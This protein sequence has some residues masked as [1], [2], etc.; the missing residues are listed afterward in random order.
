M[1]NRF[2][3]MVMNDPI[4][5]RITRFSSSKLRIQLL[6][7]LLFGLLWHPALK[8]EGTKQVMPSPTHGTAMLI[9]PSTRT[10]PLLNATPQNRL[11][12]NIKDNV[13]ED[14]YFGFNPMQRAPSK[15]VPT[16][17]YYKITDPS[18]AVV[19]PPAL[20]PLSGTGFIATYAQAIAGPNVNGLNP[21]GY[22]PLK[23][24]P[25]LSGDYYF[26][27]YRSNDAGVTMVTGNPSEAFLAYFDFTVSDAN[28]NVI[29]GR[30]H[31]QKWSFICYNP[32]DSTPGQQW[33]FLGSYFAYT[34]D[35]SVVSVNFQPGLMPLAYVL[36]MNYAGL[37]T[38]NNGNWL[39]NRAS[40]YSGAVT[41][42]FPGGYKIFLN[43]PDPTVF[44]RSAAAKQPILSNN[45]FGCP[46]NYFIPFYIDKP[47]DIALLIDL[48]GVPGY[49]AGTRDVTIELYGQTAGNHVLSWN[50]LDGLGV[51]VPTPV[52]PLAMSVILLRGRTS[53]PI[54][55]AEINQNGFSASGISPAPGPRKLYW[56]DASLMV[57]GPC[58]TGGAVQ[59][60]NNITGPGVSMTTALLGL[61]GPVHSWDG[62]GANFSVPA[63]ANGGGSSTTV[64]CDD[65]GNARIINTWFY[66][67]ETASIVE[68]LNV[69]GCDHDQDGIPDQVDIDDDN[70][71]VTDLNES[72]LVDPVA[73]ANGN[74][75]PNFIDPTYPGFI[76]LNF[77][78]VN[79]NF[80]T[81]MDGII[82]AW[83]VDSDNDGI[84][85]GVEA[86]GGTAPPGF[87]NGTGRFTGAVG[88]NGM[89]DVAET[90]PESGISILQNPDTDGDGFKDMYDLDSDNDG[91]VDIYEAQTGGAPYVPP[92]GIDADQ[93]GRDDAYDG[94]SA[95]LAADTDGDGQADYLDLDGDND[96][97]P[98]VTE[99]GNGSLDVNNDGRIDSTTDVDGDGLPDVADGTNTTNTP[100]F[101][102]GNTSDVF[103]TTNLNAP[104]N[105]V[106]ADNDGLPN[107]ADL[108]ADGD[109][110]PDITETGNGA[111]DVNNDGRIDSATD[112]D[113]DGLRDVVDGVNNN[114][115]GGFVAG[116]PSDV[117]DNDNMNN[118]S[119]DINAD[120][121]GIPNYLDLD[122]DND[123]MPDITET[124]NGILDVNND[125]QVDSSVDV[126]GDGLMDLTDG[127]NNSGAAGFTAG[128][129]GDVIDNDNMNNAS[130]DINA[131]ND[132]IPNYLDLDS[133][134]DGI[135]DLTETSNGNFDVNN[136]GMIDNATDLDLDGLMDV[137]DGMNNSAVVG[138]SS[139]AASNVIDNDN[140]NNLSNDINFDG[141]AIPNYLDLDSDNDGIADIAEALNGTLDINNDGM[142]DSATDVDMDGL[143]DAVDGVNNSGAGGFTA[144]SAGDV[145]DNDN[146]DNPAND[147]NFDLDGLPNYLDLDADNDGI[148][149]IDEAMNSPLDANNDG[150]ADNATD[151]DGDGLYDAVDGMNNTGVGGFTAGSPT[152]VVDN[153]NFNNPSND[154]NSDSD[155]QPNW[156][157]LDSDN[158]GLTDVVENANG[159]T[160]LDS[161]AGTAI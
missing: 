78:G 72:G 11:K 147:I 123:G 15:G 64:L 102:A 86:N 149:D 9:S 7:L 129:A 28:F 161:G 153:D 101:V 124:L 62:P 99:S 76:D 35:S 51:P 40:N 79:D 63:Q 91:I 52:S 104:G 6:S 8:A 48:N 138:F 159:N 67:N 127:V 94:S 100:G 131:D 68:T 49:Q 82:D 47:G 117:I 134:N 77:D 130:N 140:P 12:V 16:N 59:A 89:P 85:D 25:A 107:W 31:S 90:S 125:G 113:M 27:I 37:D 1:I 13:S 75:V 114:G 55:D 29:N 97:I 56:D 26:E 126:D 141:D 145:I 42:R 115:A 120:N 110:I 155:A 88:L 19:V 38:T 119:N 103:V 111:W 133:D 21:A 60:L 5:N 50:G 118:A 4:R 108:D 135:P 54:F 20:V 84:A 112:A 158:D 81:D 157:D 74:L 53:L 69:P 137:V 66:S 136:D 58:S 156:L 93:N 146:L 122:S 22:T 121:D 14:I 43:E 92:S 143:Q 17:L 73:D 41:P 80:D 45:V 23:L 142:I 95:L 18:G 144:G 160:S 44:V 2:Q 70:D 83:D 65:F 39:V 128:G 46:G 132:A 98:D 105:D 96:G 32:V 154:I 57:V 106:D 10:G 30:L 34:A 116:N 33:N 139:G 148:S 151:V 152:N 24:D 61:Y 109:G 71:G 150:Q 87:D 36:Y 3:V